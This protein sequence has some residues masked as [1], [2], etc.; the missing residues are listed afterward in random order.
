MDNHKNDTVKPV[1]YGHLGTN[2]RCPD[3][4]AVLIFQVS[5][6]DKAP[7]GTITKCVDYACVHIFITV[8]CIHIMRIIPMIIDIITINSTKSTILKMRWKYFTD[9]NISEY[10]NHSIYSS[11][12]LV[13][14]KI[15]PHAKLA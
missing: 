13:I 2:K 7:F 4:Q 10:D 14:L 1:Y 11:I 15:L 3:Y 8:H 9:V 6:Y 5:L 12:V